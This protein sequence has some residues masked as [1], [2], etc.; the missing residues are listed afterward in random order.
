MRLSDAGRRRRRTQ[1]LCPD[2]RRLKTKI[3]ATPAF[4]ADNMP[5]LGGPSNRPSL[6]TGEGVMFI[7]GTTPILVRR[8]MDLHDRKFLRT[9]FSNQ[10]SLRRSNRELLSNPGIK[11]R[12]RPER[13]WQTLRN[14]WNSV[15]AGG[16]QQR[17]ANGKHD[18]FA[19]SIPAWPNR[20]R[21]R[22]SL[23]PLVRHAGTSIHAR[24]AISQE[25]DP[26][27]RRICHSRI[28]TNCQCRILRQ[29]LCETDHWGECPKL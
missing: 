14:R 13:P 11:I 2:Q 1:E 24:P 12:C 18:C 16:K 5:V 4:Y 7:I 21:D 22:R 8:V 17:S 27:H 20:R 28:E 19:T 23:Q 26:Q 29:A 6:P 15:G 9:K 25:P 10:V 3:P